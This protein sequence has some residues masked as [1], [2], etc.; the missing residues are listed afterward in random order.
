MNKYIF[1]II[2]FI[3][4][5]DLKAMHNDDH[6]FLNVEYHFCSFKANMGMNDLMKSV[7]KFNSFL[8]QNSSKQSYQAAL[9]VC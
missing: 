2:V 8:K 3:F 4:F 9:L 5:P 1:L 7:K 6:K